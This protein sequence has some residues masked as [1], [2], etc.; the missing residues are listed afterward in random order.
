MET[1]VNSVGKVI[2][3]RWHSKYILEYFVGKLLEK[4][5]RLSH[6]KDRFEEP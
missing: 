3:H 2:K 5:I 4:A 6:K 1:S